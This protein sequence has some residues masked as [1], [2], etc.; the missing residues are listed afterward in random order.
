MQTGI[1]HG[2][3]GGQLH[4]QVICN[5][6]KHVP[7]KHRV[8]GWRNRAVRVQRVLTQPGVSREGFLGEEA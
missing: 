2:L 8:E 6:V 4:R 5:G 1:R 7:E 3:L